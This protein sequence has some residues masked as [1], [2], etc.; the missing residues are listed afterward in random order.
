MIILIW[1]LSWI[2]VHDILHILY[3]GIILILLCLKWIT[4]KLCILCLLR[5][6]VSI[7]LLLSDL[8]LCIWFSWKWWF[9]SRLLRNCLLLW[10]L[11][12]LRKSKWWEVFWSLWLW[13]WKIIHSRRIIRIKLLNLRF[14]CLLSTE[15]N[16]ITWVVSIELL[17]GRYF[18]R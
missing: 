11:L 10:P 2:Q 4:I 7:R 15:C 17:R 8:W 9:T 6:I 13:K 5:C 18:L 16:L 12:S 3:K 1:L 14:L